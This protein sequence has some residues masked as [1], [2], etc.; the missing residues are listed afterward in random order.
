MKRIIFSV[1]VLLLASCS[2][3]PKEE[4]LR[5]PSSDSASRFKQIDCN[6]YS[7][8]G[9]SCVYNPDKKEVE[10]AGYPSQGYSCAYNPEEK[11]VECG[12]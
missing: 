8:K 12:G 7:S 4:S 3:S 5:S 9:Y 11:K 10:C 6:G 2:H 1:C